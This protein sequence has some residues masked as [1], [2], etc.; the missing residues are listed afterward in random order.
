LHPGLVPYLVKT[1]GNDIIIQAGGG[2]HGHRLGTTAGA[3]A[4]RQ[5]IDAT[6]NNITLKEYSKNHKELNIALKQWM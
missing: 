1:L 2:I 5:A 4:M 6:L 3:I